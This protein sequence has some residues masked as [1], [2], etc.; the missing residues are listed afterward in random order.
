MFQCCYILPIPS[1]L[2]AEYVADISDPKHR[3]EQD[4]YLRHLELEND[5]PLGKQVIW[6]SPGFVIKMKKVRSTEEKE[7]MLNK[8]KID[9][10][11]SKIFINIVY[12]DK[13]EKPTAESESI[14]NERS[15]KR[16]RKWSLPYYLGPL[17]FEEDH[18]KV[19][20]QTSDCC[21]HPNALIYA[22]NSDSF[23]NLLVQS[24]R[25]GVTKQSISKGKEETI[26]PSYHILKDVK[27]K[28]GS[29][30]M[31]MCNS[32]DI[33]MVAKP[34]VEVRTNSS[35]PYRNDTLSAVKDKSIIEEGIKE[36]LLLESSKDAKS[37]IRK[38][39][40]LESDEPFL[41]NA[42]NQGFLMKDSKDKKYTKKIVKARKENID[43]DLRLNEPYYEIVEQGNFQL[44]N[45][46]QP[47]SNRPR[48]L[49]VRITLLG[50][51]SSKDINLD[52]TQHRLMLKSMNKYS[53]NLKL[54]YPVLEDEGQAKF[55]SSM[56]IL[57]ITL[58]VIS[59]TSI[60]SS[61]VCHI[62]N[63][64]AIDNTNQHQDCDELKSACLD[65]HLLC[66]EVSCTQ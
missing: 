17:R 39:N 36:N 50:I 38:H 31:M 48:V 60:K 3:A 30:P 40:S 21:F 46:M 11:K 20:V 29:P 45:E 6:P 54:P 62:P 4:S 56:S 41:K 58:P 52:I 23:R 14:V 33:K 12:S 18:N 27:Y 1:D 55:D 49:I 16:A 28:N 61:R 25:D 32:S 8:N 42:L 47:S 53:L 65:T 26:G 34:L 19:L 10:C 24:A 9:K 22:S 15:K 37:C 5:I 43:E 13:I 64:D 2:M 51:K 66:A 35:I 7:I 63:N 44:C 59:L 57:S